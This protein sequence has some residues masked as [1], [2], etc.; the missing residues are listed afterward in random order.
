MTTGKGRKP[1]GWGCIREGIWFQAEWGFVYV[2]PMNPSRIT[3]RQAQPDDMM[4]CARVFL[5]SA[6]DLARRQG[7]EAPTL[8]AKDMARSLAHVQSTDPKGFQVAVRRG[9][10]IAFASTI[11]RGKTHFLSMFWA[12]PTIQSKG[13][14]RRVLERA[15]TKPRPPKS[16]VRCVYASLDSRAQ[17]LY[18]KFGMYPRGMFYM[19]LGRP[20]RS[21]K[22]KRGVEL[23]PVGEPGVTSP[24]MLSVAARFDAR[25]RAARRDADIRFITSLPG[26][27]FFLVRARGATLGYTVITEKGRVGPACVTD[28]R[29]GAGLAWAIK[30]KAR[31]LGA[32]SISLVV[33]G[34]NA[35]A[36]E[37]FLKAGLKSPFYGAWMSGKPV[38]SFETYI[39]AGGML[40]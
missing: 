4:G 13:V 9:R 10:V 22:P 11:L 16:A 36:L 37:V 12:L 14:G 18:I 39:L 1:N 38:G 31:E 23:V 25:F 34:V 17:A 24:R 29:Y 15:F 27:R 6:T 3:F 33:P 26:A 28:P 20:K 40:L 19:L 32:E 35:S 5:A 8:R 2:P 30:E 21:P 7:T